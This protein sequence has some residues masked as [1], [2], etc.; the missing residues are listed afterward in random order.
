MIQVERL[1]STIFVF[2]RRLLVLLITAWIAD[3]AL[4]EDWESG[5]GF[6]RHCIDCETRV[7]S[8]IQPGSSSQTGIYFPI[9]FRPQ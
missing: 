4:G 9:L 5:A 6:R 1:C 3:H 2:G 8:M 7:K